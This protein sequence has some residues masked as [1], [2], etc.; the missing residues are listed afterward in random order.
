S[1]VEVMVALSVFSIGVLGTMELF[2]TC[3]H[4]T[5]DSLGYTEAVYIAQQV[6]EETIAEGNLTAETDSGEYQAANKT[7]SWTLTVEDSDISGLVKVAVAV[8]WTER[9]AEKNYTLTTLVAENNNL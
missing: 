9:A 4:S 2:S 7:F 3:L 8:T 6:I 5:S 1:L